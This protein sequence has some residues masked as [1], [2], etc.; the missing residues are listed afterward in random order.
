MMDSL[1]MQC[2]AI[3]RNIIHRLHYYLRHIAELCPDHLAAS[4]RRL[5]PHRNHCPPPCNCS[6]V[7]SSGL[8]PAPQGP[9]LHTGGIAGGSTVFGIGLSVW[10]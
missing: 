6:P 4:A 7:P 1:C 8:R 2:H 9:P 10:C 3:H 5:S